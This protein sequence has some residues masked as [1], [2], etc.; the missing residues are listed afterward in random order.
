MAGR[1]AEEE[2][3]R[4]YKH[5]RAARR[6]GS[7]VGV[8]REAAGIAAYHA[9]EWAEALAE[10]RAARRLSAGDDSYLPVMAD[11]ERG[12]GRP[13]RALDLIK[14]AEARRLDPM[15]RVELRIVE[16][17]VRR[18]LGQQDAAVVTLQ[19]PELRDRRLRPWSVRLFYAYADALA[20][21]GREEASDWFARAAA[22]DRDGETDAA[23]R[24]AELE[25]LHIVDTEEDEL[26]DAVPEP[27]DFE[28]TSLSEPM[29]TPAGEVLLGQAAAQDDEGASAGEALPEARADAQG[30]AVQSDEGVSEDEAV[31]GQESV[32]PGEAGAEAGSA[33]D[34]A[35][36]DAGSDV[37][38]A[39]EEEAPEVPAV[40]LEPKP[41]DGERPPQAE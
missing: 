5:A 29:T 33:T 18:D 28:D 16:S 9:G 38:E 39:A 4:A 35:F 22:A 34:I 8:V 25:G 20:E 37:A 1:L 24:Y 26:G 40:F 12:L 13:E 7:R 21:A 11:C 17:G 41:V 30:E 32:K 23:E 10:L 27:G 2:P 6:L 19:I 3:E 36:T 14:S 15:G 31:P